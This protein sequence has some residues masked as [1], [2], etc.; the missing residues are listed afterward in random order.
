M[1]PVDE[2]EKL[3]YKLIQI[4]SIVKENWLTY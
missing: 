2:L 1:V 4:D 3:L